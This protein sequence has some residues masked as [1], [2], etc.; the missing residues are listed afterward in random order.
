VIE[1]ISDAMAQVLSQHADRIQPELLRD[2]REEWDGGRMSMAPGHV[3][4]S[5]A[6]AKLMESSSTPSAASE[7]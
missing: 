7:P 1:R 2:M 6:K 4:Q 3:F 5:M